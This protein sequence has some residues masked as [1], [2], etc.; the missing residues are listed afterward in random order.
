VKSNG[1]LD[2]IFISLS[3]FANIVC[4]QVG[5]QTRFV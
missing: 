1:T 4:Q 2:G 5:F 3:L